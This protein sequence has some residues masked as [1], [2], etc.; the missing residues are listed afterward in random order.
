[1]VTNGWRFAAKGH[2]TTNDHAHQLKVKF[3]AACLLANQTWQTEW[4]TAPS[5]KVKLCE[6]EN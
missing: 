6:Y 1:M 5:A 4:K 3:L 2:V